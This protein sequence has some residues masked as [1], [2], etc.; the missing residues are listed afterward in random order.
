MLRQAIDVQPFELGATL[1]LRQSGES[2]A[3]RIA[4][5]ELTPF[6][7]S[8]VGAERISQLWVRGGFPDSLLALSN[9]I[10]CLD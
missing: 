1:R 2:L 4:H 5:V 7:L 9:K 8:G 6:R 3:G 10:S